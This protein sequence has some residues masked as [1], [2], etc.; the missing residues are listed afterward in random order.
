MAVRDRSYQPYKGVLTADRWRFLVIPRYAYEEVFKSRRFLT[1]LVAAFV[2]PAVCVILIY[3][4]HNLEA[5]DIMDLR[6]R[7][8][9]AIDGEFFRRFYLVQGS[10]LFAV[11]FLVGPVLVSADLSHNAL[12]MY[13]ARPLSRAEYLGDKLSVLAIVMSLGGVDEERARALLEASH[14]SV[15]D[16]LARVRAG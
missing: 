5:L 2:W 11:A 8:L 16:A 13:L 9:M 15:H 14:G 10:F 3:L 12:P 1:L 7:D 4:H 6:A